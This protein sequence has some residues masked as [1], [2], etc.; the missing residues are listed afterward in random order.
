MSSLLYGE[1]SLLV[2]TSVDQYNYQS[3]LP[4]SKDQLQCNGRVNIIGPEDKNARF[5]M[6][7]KIGIR[8]KATEYR[9]A[10]MNV[11]E[12][13]ILARVYFSS[14]NIQ[15]IQNALRK[16]V[17]DKSNGKLNIPNQNID[18]LKIIMRS[19]YLQ[20]AR[21]HPDNITEQVETLNKL[22]LDYA[23]PYVY[24]EAVFYLKYV[25]DQS[26]LVMPFQRCNKIDRDYKQLEPRF[27][28]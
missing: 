4:T 18:N 1:N 13:N 17:Y 11:W 22:V 15:I 2:G 28:V 5:K 25:E 20:H 24:N 14:E 9:G 19:V 8:N 27:W 21:H 12:D 26:T 3:V 10:L 23:I 16:G 7:E 6:A